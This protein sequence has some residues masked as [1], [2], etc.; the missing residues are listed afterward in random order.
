MQTYKEF[1]RLD[2]SL[3]KFIDEKAAV[4]KKIP[5][6]MPGKKGMSAFSLTGSKCRH[7]YD[8]Q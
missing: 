5:G 1:S 7:H 2:G 6:W 8:F 3:V 4:H